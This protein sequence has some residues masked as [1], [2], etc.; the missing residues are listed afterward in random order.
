MIIKDFYSD[1]YRRRK[2]DDFLLYFSK[3]FSIVSNHLLLVKTDHGGIN[4]EINMVSTLIIIFTET[5]VYRYLV[6]LSTTGLLFVVLSLSNRML[7]FQCSMA[8]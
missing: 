7:R 2:I 3:T 1:I 5:D 8:L 6:N 4:E